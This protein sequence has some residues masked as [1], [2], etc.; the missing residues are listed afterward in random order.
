MKRI[1]LSILLLVFFSLSPVFAETSSLVSYDGPKEIK[2]TGT[3][4]DGGLYYSLRVQ[5]DGQVEETLGV[6]SS[7]DIGQ[8]TEAGWTSPLLSFRY[9]S[10]LIEPVKSA[11]I[12]VTITQPFSLVGGIDEASA[13]TSFQIAV[14]TTIIYYDGDVVLSVDNT[15]LSIPS[16]TI[17]VGPQAG[18]LGA[19]AIKITPHASYYY[20]AGNYEGSVEVNVTPQ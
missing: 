16:R 20:P 11:A 6:N 12:S 7:F 14:P 10:N 13:M 3:I 19:F 4:P 5:S 18:T 15:K 9:S 1:A 2:L 8:L 17:P